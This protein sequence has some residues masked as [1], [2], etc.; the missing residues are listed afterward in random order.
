MTDKEKY[1]A[2][3]AEIERQYEETSIGLNEHENGIERGRMEVINA[4]QQKIDTMKEEPS[5]PDIVDEHFSEMLGENPVNNDIENEIRRYLKEDHDRDTTVGDVARHFSEWQR[6]M[7]IGKAV[8]GE[9]VKN[10]KGD[11]FAAIP[12]SRQDFEWG[13]EVNGIILKKD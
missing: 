7:M 5:I 6:K 4:L 9:I 3:V 10:K 13:E 2:L 11:F 12:V 8:D 1:D